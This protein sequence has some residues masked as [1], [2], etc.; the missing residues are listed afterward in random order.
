M[1]GRNRV[2]KVDFAPA[3]KTSA[4]RTLD[5]CELTARNAVAGQ[6]SGVGHRMFALQRAQKDLGAATEREAVEMALSLVTFRRELRNG[7]R[8]LR[9]LKLARID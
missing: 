2:V 8:A 4:N 6:S 9:K 3:A 5:N 1:T 7:V